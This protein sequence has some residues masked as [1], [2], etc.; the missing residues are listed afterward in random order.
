MAYARAAAAAGGESDD[1]EGAEAEEPE[2]EEQHE[3]VEEA[4]GLRLHLS[5]SS[6]TGYRNVARKPSGRFG[7]Q[8]Y[9]HGKHHSLGV[10]DTAVEAAV[11]YARA[12]AAER[13]PWDQAA[14]AAE[15][16]EEEDDENKEE[17]EQQQQ[18]QQE[19]DEQ[20]EGEDEAEQEQHEVVEEAEGWRLHLSRRTATGYR[21][22]HPTSS[23]AVESAA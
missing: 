21:G 1:H 7:S 13:A 6:G 12:A 17:E 16:E 20:E 3:V 23:A 2:E 19:E 22:V 9:R 18:Q 10:F 15:V 5:S 14:A 4:E 8:I 11:A